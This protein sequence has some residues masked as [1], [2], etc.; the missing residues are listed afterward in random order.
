VEKLKRLISIVCVAM[1]LVQISSVAH[2]QAP[3]L[4]VI[5]HSSYIHRVSYTTLYAYLNIVAKTYRIYKGT[6]RIYLEDKLPSSIIFPKNALGGHTAQVKAYINVKGM[7][8][9][10]LDPYIAITHE[11]AEMAVD[12]HLEDLTMEICDNNLDYFTLNGHT[13]SGFLGRT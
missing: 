3:T 5:N 4:I 2:A 6:Y 9:A 7:V 12:P 11:L 8:E 13:V 1:G 10:K